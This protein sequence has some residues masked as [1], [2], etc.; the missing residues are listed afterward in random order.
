MGRRDGQVLGAVKV[1]D[2]GD[3][4]ARWNLVVV[5]DGY[6]AEEMEK[7]ARDVRALCDTLFATAPFGEF[8]HAINVYRVDVTSTDSGADDPPACGGPGTVAATYFD[9][10]FC[11]YNIRRL[12]LVDDD[13]VL[14][15]VDRLV[16]A[17]HVILVAVNTTVHGGSGGVVGTYSMAPGAV[18]IALHEIGHT[19]FGLADEYEYWAGCDVD[20]DRDRH[21]PREP[22]EP[23]VTTK[24]ER[25]ELKWRDLV[26]PETAIP[27]TKNK[28]CKRCDSQPNP[29]GD[30]VIGAFEGA[31]YHHCGAFRPA[32]GCMMR[33]LGNPFC[34]VCQRQI[35]RVLTAFLPT[36]S[37]EVSWLSALA[38][39]PRAVGDP[40]VA[41]HPTRGV[42]V[43]L[44]RGE[45]GHLH[46]LVFPGPSGD[47]T[48]RDLTVTAGAPL[49]EG[50]PSAAVFE[51]GGR[52]VVYRAID[53]ELVEL[54]LRDAVVDEGNG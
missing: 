49:A 9:A 46:E 24:S 53:G 33:A 52:R 22:T 30:A 34:T 13:L 7:F 36:P 12:L 23:N 39:A 10:S 54:W 11:H 38:S 19:A 2:H 31:H 45:Q 43:V 16:P 35:A 21:P 26:S 48:H 50:D 18:Q 4:A 41:T 32:Y 44:Y 47:W 42:R 37:A 3:P 17:W 8:R 6:R 28:N 5:S 25:A 29:V 1:V 51:P 40:S 15:T 14:E 20:K 27:T